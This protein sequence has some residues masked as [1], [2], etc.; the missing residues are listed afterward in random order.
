MWLLC[1]LI[2]SVLRIGTER[3]YAGDFKEKSHSLIVT[4]LGD[5]RLDDVISRLTDVRSRLADVDSSW[6]P[7]LALYSVGKS[8]R[9]FPAM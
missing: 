1:V 5:A 3:L 2:A 6:P 8:V 9:L 7:R 4:S